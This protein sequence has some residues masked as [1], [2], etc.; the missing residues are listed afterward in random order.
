MSNATLLTDS[1]RPAVRLERH[2]S[3]PPPV[4]WHAITERDQ[5]RS[6]FPCDVIVAGGRWVV[7]AAIAFL[8]PPEDIDLTLTGEV[9]AVDEPNLLSFTWGEETL[10]FELS[11]EDGGT[12]FVLIDEL[13]AGSAARNAAGWDTC[14]DRLAGLNVESTAWKSRFEAYAAAFEP[15]IGPQE[16]PP[17]NY[18]GD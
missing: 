1:V 16:G 3:D 12:R 17:Q 14:L 6:W 8:F 11:P 18:K 9:L 13:P 5:I 7:G 2:L 4:V 10:H 15:V